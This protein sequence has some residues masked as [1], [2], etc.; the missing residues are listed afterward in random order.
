MTRA[1]F[2]AFKFRFTCAKDPSTGQLLDL[3]FSAK[4]FV[5]VEKNFGLF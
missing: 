5:K 3:E 2:E 4:D 1:E